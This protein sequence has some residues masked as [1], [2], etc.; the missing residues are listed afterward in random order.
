MACSATRERIRPQENPDY[1][2]PA[3]RALLQSGE[4]DAPLEV[5]RD[6][7]AASIEF[8]RQKAQPL[9]TSDPLLPLLLSR[10]RVTVELEQGVGIAAPQV[11]ISRQV[12]WVLRLDKTPDMPFEA[13]VNPQIIALSEENLTDW[14]GCLSVTAGF[15]KVT[16]PVGITVKY[17]TADGHEREENVSGFTARIF[18]HEIDH[19]NG[20]LFIDRMN[21]G[22][23]LMPKEEFRAMRLREKAE[24][25]AQQNPPTDE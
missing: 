24:K 19:L 20:V 4:A 11:G 14:E 5:V 12:I 18:Q 16:R 22:D 23:A 8:L 7:D 6:S 13:Y 1:F 9:S 17:L 3:E 25:D 21:A 2:S 15:G 10:M